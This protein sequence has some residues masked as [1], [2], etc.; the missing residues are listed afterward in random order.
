MA[1]YVSDIEV[2]EKYR[3]TQTGIEGH[4]TALIFFQ[5]GCE[6]VDIEF[7][8][9]GKIEHESFDAARLVHIDS[10]KQAETEKPGGPARESSTL[11][12]RR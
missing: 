11:R 9:E 6:R 10:G 4:A 8:R 12:K 3:D 5:H 7:V 2:G 1:V